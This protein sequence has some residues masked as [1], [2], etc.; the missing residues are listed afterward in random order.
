MAGMGVA[1][2]KR[3]VP[4]RFGS[5]RAAISVVAEQEQ[6]GL[7]GGSDCST[8]GEPC[9]EVPAQ[10]QTVARAVTRGGCANGRAT[11]ERRGGPRRADGLSARIRMTRATQE[12]KIDATY[13]RVEHVAHVPLRRYV[14]RSILQAIVACRTLQ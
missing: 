8:P 5:H 14:A 11:G 12:P 10:T 9:D 3:T 6:F 2:Q 4:F 7:G 13:V 1:I